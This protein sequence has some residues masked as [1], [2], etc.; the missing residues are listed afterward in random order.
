[1]SVII[2]IDVYLSIRVKMHAL[3]CT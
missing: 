3:K 2:Q 1:M